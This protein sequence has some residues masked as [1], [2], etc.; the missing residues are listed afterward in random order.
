ML[1]VVGYMECCD[2]DGQVVEYCLNCDF[3]VYVLCYNCKG[4]KV[5]QG[6]GVDNMWCIMCINCD[7]DF[8]EFV[9]LFI[10]DSVSVDI[11]IVQVYCS[12]L[13]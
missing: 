13:F 3:G 11:K 8:D 7:F 12:K 9:F 6:I 2:G 4:E 10:I 1:I 5:M